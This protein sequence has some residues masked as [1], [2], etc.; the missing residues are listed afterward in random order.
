VASPHFNLLTIVWEVKLTTCL[1]LCG[2]SR[3]FYI[4]GLCIFS[5]PVE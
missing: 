2:T 5:G 3:F 1:P 4:S